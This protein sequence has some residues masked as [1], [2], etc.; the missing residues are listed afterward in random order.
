VHLCCTS[1]AAGVEGPRG[2]LAKP[3]DGVRD[4]KRLSLSPSFPSSMSIFQVSV[5]RSEVGG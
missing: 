3:P 2:R 4:K 5:E 1:H